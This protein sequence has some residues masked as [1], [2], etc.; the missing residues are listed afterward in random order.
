MIAK[1]IFYY[2]DV[3]SDLKQGKLKNLYLFHGKEN[4]L[5]EDIL[6]KVLEK[7]PDPSLKDINSK[8]LYGE[9]VMANDIIGELQTVPF[10]SK[11]KLV[12]IKRAEKV[13]K[14]NREN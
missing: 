7:L 4:Y 9:K 8:T 11:Q 10:F 3:L 5:K 1:K 2:R 13:N 14:E 12:I 6:K